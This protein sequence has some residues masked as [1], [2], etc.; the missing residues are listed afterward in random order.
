MKIFTCTLLWLFFLFG[1]GW[2][3]AADKASSRLEFR[4]GFSTFAMK[5][6]K[7]FNSEL[8]NE[9]QKRIPNLKNTEN[10]PAFFSYTFTYYF[11][12][13]Q[14]PWGFYLNYSST[15]SRNTYSDYSG[16]IFQDMIVRRMLVGIFTEKSIFVNPKNEIYVALSTGQMINWLVINE[17][18]KIGEEKYSIKNRFWGLSLSFEPSVGYRF[19]YKQW[20]I[21]FYIGYELDLPNLDLRYSK[22]FKAKIFH[23]SRPVNPEWRGLRLGLTFA[24]PK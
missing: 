5:D 8:L 11:P 7:S 20:K 19:T 2:A 24:Y 12:L 23:N 14:T 4:I 6:L 22:Q 10:F 21:G 15:G 9:G 16:T 18:L 1:N 13:V 17:E 3:Q